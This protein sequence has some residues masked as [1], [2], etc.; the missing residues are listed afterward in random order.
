MM[1]IGC[2]KN[3][4][5]LSI[6]SIIVTPLQIASVSQEYSSNVIHDQSL[7]NAIQQGNM[8]DVETLVLQG[9]DVNCVA[10]NPPYSAPLHHAAQKGLKDIVVFLKDHGAG[11]HQVN[12]HDWTPLHYAAWY[13]RKEIVTLLIA[14]GAHINAINTDNATPLALAALRKNKAIVALLLE[15]GAYINPHYYTA[16]HIINGNFSPLEYRDY[17]TPSAYYTVQTVSQIVN[18][19]PLALAVI[20][21]NTKLVT[22][23]LKETATHEEPPTDTIPQDFFQELLGSISNAVANYFSSQIVPPTMNSDKLTMMTP[24]HWAA[25]QGRAQHITFLLQYGADKTAKNKEGLT[26]YDIAVRNKELAVLHNNPAQAQL[27]NA[28]MEAL[29]AHEE[30]DT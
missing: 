8:A 26:A 20:L 14:W 30:Q 13:D 9:A 10:I 3:K 6:I 4:I 25:A 27:Y 19:N 23:L 18:G 5:F 28:S 21:C 29:Q 11:I 16:Y 17:F 7:I 1:T 15:Y 12:E 22:Q 24:L 2:V